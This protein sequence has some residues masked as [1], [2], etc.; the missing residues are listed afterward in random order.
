M[1]RNDLDENEFGVNIDDEDEFGLN[2]LPPHYAEGRVRNV[3]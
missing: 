1:S 3:P 2:V